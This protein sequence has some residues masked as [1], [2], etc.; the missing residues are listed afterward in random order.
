MARPGFL[1][2]NLHRSYPFVV[3]QEGM[4]PD[5]AVVDFGTTTL[6][7]SGFVEGQH[8]IW[9]EWI[10]R[11]GDTIEF[12][13]LSDAPGL[14]GRSLVFRRD[15]SDPKFVTSYA[16]G[17]NAYSQEALEASC[18]CGP[19]LVCNPSFDL[20][21]AEAEPG[22]PCNQYPGSAVFGWSV[23]SLVTQN[24]LLSLYVPPLGS[25]QAK[26]KIVG[27]LVPGQAVSLFVDLFSFVGNDTSGVQI[28]LYG[29]T[30][31]DLLTQVTVRETGTHTLTAVVPST[32]DLW[33][34]IRAYNTSSTTA[35]TAEIDHVTLQVCV[36]TLY[37][38]S[39]SSSSPVIPPEP[40]PARDCPADT[41]WEGFLVT[42]DMDCLDEL[43]QDCSREGPRQTGG[44]PVDVLFVTDTTGSMAS[45]INTIK[46]IFAPMA[47]LV[48]DALPGVSFRWGVV[49]YKDF[50]D[51]VAYVNGWQIERTFTDDI[52][53]V[54]SAINTWVAYGGGDMPEQ[55]LATL[56]KVGEQ[57]ES[58]LLGRAD[59]QRLVIWGGDVV[60]WADGAKGLAYP[61]LA[62]T[63]AALVAANVRVFGVN[64]KTSGDGIDGDGQATA[65]CVATGG[66]LTNNVTV[67]STDEIAELVASRIIG[68]VWVPGA[69][70]VS[71]VEGPAYVEPSRI[72]NLEASYVR[73]LVVANDPRTR[74]DVVEGCADLCFSYE[75]R[76]CVSCDCI[77]G[78]V[79]FVEGY[80]SQ[81][82]IDLQANA[83]VFDAQ[84][85]GGAGLTCQEVPACYDELMVPPG[86]YTL[87]GSL[88]CEDVVRTLNGSGGQFFRIRSGTG[89]SIT[90]MPEHNRI[91]I[92]FSMA[93]MAACMEAPPVEP[94]ARLED[95]TADC[96]CGSIAGYPTST[97]PPTTTAFPTTTT[98]TPTTAGPTL[99][100]TTA[101]PTTAAPP[102]TPAPTTSE[103]TTPTPPTTPEPTTPAPPTTPEPD[104]PTEILVNRRWDGATFVPDTAA[105]VAS[106]PHWESI[107]NVMGGGGGGI[108]ALC[109]EPEIVTFAVSPVRCQGPQLRMFSTGSY[110]DTW[111]WQNVSASIVP[112]KRYLVRAYRVPLA[113][114][115]RWGL[116]SGVVSGTWITPILVSGSSYE[117]VLRRTDRFGNLIPNTGYCP[118]DPGSFYYRE[119]VFETVPSDLC[120]A[121]WTNHRWVGNLPPSP[122]QG[123]ADL[124]NP[125]IIEISD[126]HYDPLI[127][128]LESPW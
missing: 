111:L 1:N 61:S 86:R 118:T 74:A 122:G 105:V 48:K 66:Q 108:V 5:C 19:N 97:A 63:I 102:T 125:S 20:L 46:S 12:E 107:S 30:E 54:Q 100:P 94:S 75:P 49:S 101:T 18:M 59:S 37:G 114:E 124:M 69:V 117:Y 98:A 57:W 93:N 76:V 82:R 11:V 115:T 8:K 89:V 110:G 80:N 84:L 95:S 52:A 27:S 31:S 55:Q 67:G 65:I 24:G 92:E 103:P 126:M 85:G 17:G 91:I 119:Y 79:R 36:A 77:A 41:V 25:V 106:I 26:Q 23:D 73:S 121:F 16:W 51:G 45:Y 127:H 22:D 96:S 15:R 68:A 38:S 109:Q 13:F 104:D 64:D 42:G 33:V 6:A 83:I 2:D 128:A 112:G 58:A 120:L 62:A 44:G 40:D 113:G 87:S 116:R 21:E 50:E 35:L 53:L 34:H 39:S 123:W 29:P 10:R 4:I 56:K 14:I 32:P 88:R 78:A 9:L 70:T 7:A 81:I 47:N 28:S 43:L 90:D 71:L 99:E 3:G 72:R 60:G